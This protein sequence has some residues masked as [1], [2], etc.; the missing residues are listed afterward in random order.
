MPAAAAAVGGGCRWGELGME[1]GSFNRAW[2]CE[3]MQ[4]TNR[5]GGKGGG[6]GLQG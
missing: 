4:A 2:P 3:F 5:K 6:T 1:W